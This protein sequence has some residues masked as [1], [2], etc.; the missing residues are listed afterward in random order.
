VRLDLQGLVSSPS[1]LARAPVFLLALLIV[2]GLAAAPYLPA[3]GRRTTAAA[4]LLQATTLPFIVTAT[5]IGMATGQLA[6][7]TA[8]ALVCAGLLSV[9]VFPA[10][11]LTLLRGG[12][13]VSPDRSGGSAVAPAARGRVT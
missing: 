13:D 12:A 7:A 4:A 2:R 9:L 5:Q 11:A 1:A 6:P 3:F 8:A 10:A